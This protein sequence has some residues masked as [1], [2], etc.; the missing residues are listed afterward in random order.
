[1]AIAATVA[2]PLFNVLIGLGTSQVLS[3]LKNDDPHNAYIRFS[4]WDH[5]THLLRLDMLMILSLIYCQIFVLINYL[6]N[7][8]KNN[9]KISYRMSLI[10]LLIYIGTLTIILAVIFIRVLT[11]SVPSSWNKLNKIYRIKMINLIKSCFI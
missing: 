1:M 11:V 8:V 4:L 7:A 9:F 6:M 5:K 2:G 10:G 3:I